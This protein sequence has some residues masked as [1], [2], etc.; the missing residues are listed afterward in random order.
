MNSEFHIPIVF[1]L[2]LFKFCKGMV[3]VNQHNSFYFCYY[4]MYSFNSILFLLNHDKNDVI[5]LNTVE[6]CFE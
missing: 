4:F 2:I 6:K 5:S 3:Y 1:M